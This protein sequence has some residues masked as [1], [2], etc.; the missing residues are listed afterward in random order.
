MGRVVTVGMAT[1]GVAA[2]EAAAVVAKAA[3]ETARR[4]LV[5]R[6]ASAAPSWRR[7]LQ[8]PS[9]QG[10]GGRN[11]TP[12]TPVRLVV[13]LLEPTLL[14]DA[15][16]EFWVRGLIVRHLFSSMNRVKRSAEA[17]TRSRTTGAGGDSSACVHA[18]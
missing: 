12:I 17:R 11:W 3:A 2:R 4:G 13:H 18:D 15:S 10:Q 5:A 8:L 1:A 9:W 6:G 14:F 7:S 16:F